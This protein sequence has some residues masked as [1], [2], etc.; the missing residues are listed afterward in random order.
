MFNYR[1]PLYLFF[2]CASSVLASGGQPL[3]P[4]SAQMDKVIHAKQN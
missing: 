2:Y 1:F 4:L 3:Q